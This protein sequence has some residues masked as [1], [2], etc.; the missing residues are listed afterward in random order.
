MAFFS[1]STKL[2][3]QEVARALDKIRQEYDHYIVR[4]MKTPAVKKQFEDRIYMADL[5]R[6]D[7]TFFIAQEMK[8]LQELIVQAETEKADAEKKAFQAGQRNPGGKSYADRVLEKLQK[9]IEDY[10]TLAVHPQASLDV[11]KLY[12]TILWIY[13]NLWPQLAPILRDQGLPQRMVLEDEFSA[14]TPNQGKL[15][16]DL[17]HLAHLLETGAPL[18]QQSQQQKICLVKGA[19]LV[20]HL[21]GAVELLEGRRLPSNQTPYLVRISAYLRKTIQDFRLKNI[22][23][24]T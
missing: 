5:K 10:P 14:C 11:E 2:K 1:K 13:Q 17:D 4:Y 24:T 7:M 12:G 18:N 15:P 3:P 22:L 19:A 16:K 6:M 20:G 8:V 9:Q 23:P 21:L